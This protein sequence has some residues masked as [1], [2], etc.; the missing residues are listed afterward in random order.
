MIMKMI[1]CDRNQEGK[2]FAENFSRT[3]EINHSFKNKW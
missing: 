2:A 3:V 1:P